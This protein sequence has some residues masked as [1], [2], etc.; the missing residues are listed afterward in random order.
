MLRRLSRAGGDAIA[1]SWAPV[2][3]NYE[4]YRQQTGW[5]WYWRLYSL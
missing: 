5:D 4:S 2:K 1:L 3:K